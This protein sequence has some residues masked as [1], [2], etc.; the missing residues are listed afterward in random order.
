MC[1]TERAVEAIRKEHARIAWELEDQGRFDIAAGNAASM[2][3]ELA[4]FLGRREDRV[5]DAVLPAPGPVENLRLRIRPGCW[6]GPGQPIRQ[7][8][9]DWPQSPT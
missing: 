6:P 7:K 3:S 9:V 2:L 5:G 1:W 4:K 8:G